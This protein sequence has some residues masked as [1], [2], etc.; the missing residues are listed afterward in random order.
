M[1]VAI[2]CLHRSV[3]KHYKIKHW[4]RWIW[5]S[6]IGSWGLPFC[7]HQG[8]IIVNKYHDHGD[9]YK[10]KHLLGVCLHI[11]GYSPLSSW[12]GG[13]W[14]A[15]RHVAEE[16]AER[17]TSRLIGIWKKEMSHWAWLG[18][19]K[20]QRLYLLIL[21]TPWWLSIQMYEPTGAILI[22]TIT[23]WYEGLCRALKRGW[24]VSTQL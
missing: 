5:K 3:L 21:P 20:P 4:L 2:A 9:F 11:Q 22:Q 23:P 19:L 8:S 7:L 12:Q 14:H 10:R 16:V 13:W 6:V 24:D 15:G 18:L 1:L 17:S